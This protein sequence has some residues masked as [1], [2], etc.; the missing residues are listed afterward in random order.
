MRPAGSARGLRRTCTR[1]ADRLVNA[2]VLRA[3]IFLLS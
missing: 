3:C 2:R 1:P